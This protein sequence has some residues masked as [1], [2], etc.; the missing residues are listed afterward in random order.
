MSLRGECP[1]VIKVFLWIN[2]T[3]CATEIKVI[4]KNTIKGRPIIAVVTKYVS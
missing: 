1:A 3:Y 2:I 4:L